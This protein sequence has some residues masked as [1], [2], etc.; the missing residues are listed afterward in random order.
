MSEDIGTV[1]WFGESWNAP[2]CDPRALVET[3]VGEDCA[4]GS[5]APIKAG[6][7]GVGIPDGST[8]FYVWYHLDCWLRVIGGQVT[9]EVLFRG[10]ESG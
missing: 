3:P 6:D 5:G 9:E 10:D 4:W 7:Q 2:V 1:R 8:G